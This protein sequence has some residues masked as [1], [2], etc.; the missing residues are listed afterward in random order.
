MPMERQEDRSPTGNRRRRHYRLSAPG[1]LADIGTQYFYQSTC[2]I[3]PVALL[4]I[5]VGPESPPPTALSNRSRRTVRP[6]LQRI[7]D[8]VDEHTR[9]QRHVTARRVD[10]IEIDRIDGEM[11]EELD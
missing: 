3:D 7:D 9:T 5:A 2:C 4:N 11:C 6:A 10:Q 1:R 8:I